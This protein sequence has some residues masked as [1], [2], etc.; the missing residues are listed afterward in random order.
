[1]AQKR[2]NG[3]KRFIQKQ[4]LWLRDDSPCEG[5]SLL[6]AAGKLRRIL[7]CLLLQAD[8]V[9]DIVYLLLDDI[10]VCFF[11]FQAESDIL[12]NRHIRKQTVLLK[13]HTD[14]P[15][16]GTD[17]GDIL[18]IKKNLSA[19]DCFQTGQTA[20]QGALSAAGRTE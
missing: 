14:A 17:I 4:N 8:N 16:S 20:E 2:V 1:M 6:L 15:I 11:D 5:G 10:F 13:N 18:S 9:D 19:A 3:R 7:F 12:F